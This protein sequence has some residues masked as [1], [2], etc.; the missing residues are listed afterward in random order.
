VSGGVLSVLLGV[1]ACGMA[2]L[3]VPSLVAR[4]PEPHREPDS[5]PDGPSRAWPTY[6]EIASAPRLAGTAALVSALAGGL[7]GVA[8]GAEWP[9]LF[10]LPLVPVGVALAVVDLRRHLL[11]TVVVWPTF[12]GV[13][14]LATVSALLADDLGALARGAAA[15]AIVFAVF[16]AVWWIH[17]PGLGFGD[18]RLSAVLGL[19]LGYVGWGELVVGVYS[20]FLAFAVPGLAVA[21]LRRDRGV[22]R[23]AYPFGPFLLGGALVGLLLGPWLWGH[24]VSV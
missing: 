21:A 4:I 18:V 13:A 8:I 5:E 6:A 15:A 19:A 17:P 23:A 9:L 7:V 24:L 16:Y 3:G 11:P 20:G 10:L 22:L 2:G 12:A 14:V 1:L